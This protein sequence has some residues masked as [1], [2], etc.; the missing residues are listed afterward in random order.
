MVA[1]IC[2]NFWENNVKGLYESLTSELEVKIL[3]K[4]SGLEFH[5]P[6][7][8]MYERLRELAIVGFS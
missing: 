2:C 6:Q 5:S 1:N 3:H 8:G 7:L 4:D